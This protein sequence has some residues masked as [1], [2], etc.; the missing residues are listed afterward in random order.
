LE[1][2]EEIDGESGTGYLFS[3]RHLE[4]TQQ[5]DLYTSPR[6]LDFYHPDINGGRLVFSGTI[7][8]P[9]SR[10]RLRDPRSVYVE[11][12]ELYEDR[13]IFDE[14]GNVYFLGRSSQECWMEKVQLQ[15][16]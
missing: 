6:V 1:E 2:P 7:S 12:T 8:L 5:G 15:F 11:R 16:K 10:Y 3:W 4:A 14:A 9:P 13:L